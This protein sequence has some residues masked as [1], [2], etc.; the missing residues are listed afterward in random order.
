MGCEWPRRV[1]DAASPFCL[2]L[3][4][5]PDLTARAAVEE[6]RVHFR[7]AVA[8]GRPSSSQFL[9]F[10]KVKN[11]WEK[12]GEILFLKVLQRCTY[13]KKC[14]SIIGVFKTT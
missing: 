9:H 6:I 4:F 1:L 12:R 10:E 8:S 3:C 5:P 11:K 13:L 2:G 7:S 14:N